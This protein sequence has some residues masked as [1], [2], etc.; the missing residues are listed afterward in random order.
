MTPKVDVFML[1]VNE[2]TNGGKVFIARDQ[3]GAVGPGPNSGT[4]T[5]WVP[6]GPIVVMDNVTN[7]LLIFGLATSDEIQSLDR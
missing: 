7:L 5:V 1:P 6:G 3:V 4:A 2:Y